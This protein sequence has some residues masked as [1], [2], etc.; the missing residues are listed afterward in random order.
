MV[1]VLLLNTVPDIQ[2]NTKAV[3]VGQT[4]LEL[5]NWGGNMNSGELIT[6]DTILG[7]PPNSSTS[8]VTY[9]HVN[10]HNNYAK[11]RNE[12]DLGT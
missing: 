6:S 2:N 9:N 8:W 10:R 5:N 12:H 3:I 7:T 4:R 11:H 1:E